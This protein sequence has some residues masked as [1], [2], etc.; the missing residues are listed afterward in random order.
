MNSDSG[1]MLRQKQTD[2]LPR[3]QSGILHSAI[4]FLWEKKA[5]QSNFKPLNADFHALMQFLFR[6]VAPRITKLIAFLPFRSG[7]K[8]KK[9]CVKNRGKTSCGTYTPTAIFSMSPAETAGSK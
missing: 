9:C 3:M 6:D 8:K 1:S 2:C 7:K 5:S 4:F